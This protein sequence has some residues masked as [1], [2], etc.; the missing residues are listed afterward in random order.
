MFG[1]CPG[2]ANMRTPTLSIKK[3]PECGHDVELFSIDLK[4]A[5]DNCGFM[6]YNEISGCVQWCKHARECLGE[7]T[8][9][10]LMEEEE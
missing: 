4:V 3:C 9:R 8:Y 2:S 1:H 5:C 7:E 10:K 6:I